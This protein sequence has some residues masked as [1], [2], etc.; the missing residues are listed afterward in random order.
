LGAPASGRSL[1]AFRR[2]KGKERYG[3]F[4][5]VARPAQPT[6]KERSD[7]TRRRR[8]GPTR[9]RCRDAVI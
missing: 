6:G 7:R 1:L 2:G 8:A 9:K 3:V 4:S 5:A